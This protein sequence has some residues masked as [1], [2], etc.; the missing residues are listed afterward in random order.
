V[1]EALVTQLST[2]SSAT[3]KVIVPKWYLLPED[4][5]MDFCNFSLNR[6]DILLY[7]AGGAYKRSEF[8]NLIRAKRDL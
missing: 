5:R 6:K 7:V 3:K 4:H 2:A 1:K 8:L